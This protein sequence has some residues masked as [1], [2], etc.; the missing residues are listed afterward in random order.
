MA[1]LTKRLAVLFPPGMTAL[2]PRQL[3]PADLIRLLNST[4]LGTV[5]TAKQIA[6]HRD[7]A[8]LRIA[9]AGEPK[10]IDLLR[11]A[12]WLHEERRRRRGGAIHSFTESVKPATAYEAHKERARTRQAEISKSGRDIGE[13]PAIADPERRARTRENLRPFLET[14]FPQR[15]SLA[16]SDDHLRVIANIEAAALRGELNALAMPRGSGKTTLLECAQMWV[17]LHGHRRFG[18]IIGADKPSA[19]QILESIKS[20]LETN[21]LLAAD[22]PEVC[23]PIAKLDGIAQR[24]NGQLHKGRRTRIGWTEDVLILPTIEG[25]AASGGIIRVAGITGRI[26]GMKHTLSDGS[27][28][29]PDFALIDD[30]QTDESARSPLQNAKRERV[31]SGA[32]LGLAGPGKKIAA[33]ASVTVIV[34]GDMADRLLDRA[35][36]P[37]WHGERCRLVYEWPKREDFWR[38]YGDLRAQDLER[39]TSKARAFYVEHREEMDAGARVGWPARFAA[40]EG[41]ISAIQHAWNLRLRDEA[42]FFAEYQNDPLDETQ[43]AVGALTPELL[44]PKISPKRGVARGVVPLYCSRLTAMIDVQ[45]DALWYLVAGFGDGFSGAIIDAGVWPDQGVD[46]CT[47]AG[48]RVSY[49]A[50]RPG[51]AF[52]GQCYGALQDLCDVLLGRKWLNEAGAQMSIERMLIDA[53]WGQSTEIVHQFCRESPHRAVVIPSKGMGVGPAQKPITEYEKKPGDQIGHH[54]FIKAATKRGARQITLDTNW[55]KSFAAER[56]RAAPADKGSVAIYRG[57]AGHHRMLVDQFTS[58]YPVATTARGRTVDVWKDRPNRDNHMW[59]CFVGC[60]VAASMLGVT[61]VGQQGAPVARK[62]IR[63]S[64]IQRGNR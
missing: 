28:I 23:Y 3:R 22:F 11:Y 55:W 35:K 64:D 8:G 20:E 19:V 1:G 59:D 40:K 46:Y 33:F 14:Y 34:K 24:A 41:E 31:I 39:G 62:R 7:A 32:I 49:R 52:E 25:S 13:L 37:D 44:E 15:F 29:R 51:A 12:A 43:T 5:I 53:G 30:P 17:K 63:L 27:V 2:N 50:K 42:A 18:V 58:E 26:R 21:E 38:T 6:A 54:W 36:H 61:A 10:S 47:N 9:A 60:C 48:V 45:G 57:S 4:P 56:L 16:W